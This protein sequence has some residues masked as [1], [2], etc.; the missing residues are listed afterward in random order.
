L[1]VKLAIFDLPSWG[2]SHRL[3]YGDEY[4][5][6]EAAL[7]L[8]DFG[9]VIG[10]LVGAYALLVVRAPLKSIAKFF[11]FSSI[12]LL[13]IYLTLEVN[14]FLYAY[15]PGMRA[16]GISIL[17]TL[18]ALGLILRGIRRNVRSLR[19]LGLGLFAVVAW[20]VFFADLAQLDQFY[21]IIAFI[22]LGILTLC[23]SFV[24]LKYREQ[25]AIAEAQDEEST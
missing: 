17:W 19:Y 14:A 10:F 7:R 20:K 25:F 6:R 13:F 1:L 12:A 15:V 3:L 24:Y 18:F 23:G 22:V 4:S 5:F 2:L 8:L 21:R 11:G 9:A 16:G